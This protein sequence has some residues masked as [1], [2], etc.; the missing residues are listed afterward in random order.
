MRGTLM[1]LQPDD[2]L[3]MP[4]EM[5]NE[6]RCFSQLSAI[7]LPPVICVASNDD[8]WASLLAQNLAARGVSTIQCD[9]SDLK[10]QVSSIAD[11]SWVVIDGG[12][13]MVELEDAVEDLNTVLGQCHVKS[14]MVVDELVGPHPLASFQPN[15]VVNRTPDMRVLVRELLS[16]FTSAS[17]GQ[18]EAAI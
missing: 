13:P 8:I 9:L 17:S 18:P 3:N 7:S 14:V 16:I 11:H 12:W 15:R 2:S 1:T 4:L 6:D 10:L 5:P